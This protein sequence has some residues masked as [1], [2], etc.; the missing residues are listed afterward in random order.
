MLGAV[1]QVLSWV[2]IA[3]IP[4]YQEI[5]RPAFNN[6][7]AANMLRHIQI[8]ASDEY[9]GRAPGSRGEELT[10][11]YLMEQFQRLSL[12]PG[13]PD[14]TYVQKVP[15]VG[16]R[17]RATGELRVGEK[18]VI[19]GSTEDWVAVSRHERPEI[20]VSDSD[21]VFVGYGAVAPEY[22]WNDFKDLDV[23]GKT[24]VMLVGDPPVPDPE[25]PRKLD[26]KTFGGRTM[27]YYGRWTYKFEIASEKG[28]AAVLLVHETEPA[29][30]PYSVVQG[31]WSQENFDLADEPDAAKRVLIESWITE[32]KA[33]ELFG[34]AGQDFDALKKSAASR[35]FQPVS[36][37]A[38]AKL[39]ARNSTRRITSRNVAARLDGVDP[40]LRNEVVI[41]T[42]HWDHLGMDS[43]LKGDKIYNGAADNASGVAALLE[44]AEGFIHTP[45]RPNRSILFLF[46]TAEEK[47]L[48][49]AKYYASHPLYPLEST[50]AVINLDVVNLWGPTRDLTVVGYGLSSLDDLVTEVAA[51]RGRVVGPD[52]EPEK[53]MYYR[54]DHF[55][56]AKKGV[57]A[58]DPKPGN[59]FIGKDSSYGQRV[60]EQYTKLDYHK[61]SDEVKAE[62]D[63]RG[64]LEDLKIFME[65]GFRV[66][67]EG[68]MPQWKPGTQFRLRREE[69]LK[70]KADAAAAAAAAAG[71]EAEKAKVEAGNAGSP[72]VRE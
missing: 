39:S 71:A 40:N 6:L 43:N 47:G 1:A 64:C 23:R 2:L 19:L 57:P 30:Y 27:T 13:N 29:G 67:T 21:V 44:M 9:E 37:G 3:Q 17:T 60:R 65:V 31:S 38:K 49:G 4:N 14:G 41:Y 56:F 25:D 42:A 70:K 10:V 32:G 20:E 28:A 5:L 18:S 63:L 58:L 33:R 51:S 8:L 50:A 61:P 45:Y 15:L 24:L 12:Q 69:M 66:G 59:V 34:A 7:N 53:G 48:L 68:E 35:E 11:S 55:E 16:F 52:A 72:P 36:L 22:Q 54:S 26:V 62:W 46:V